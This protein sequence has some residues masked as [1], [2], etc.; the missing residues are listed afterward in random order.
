M[1]TKKSRA[2]IGGRRP[3]VAVAAA[4]ALAIVGASFGAAAANAVTPPTSATP[5]LSKVSS[6]TQVP[7]YDF[8]ST[9]LPGTKTKALRI[10]NSVANTASDYQMISQLESPQIAAAG[11]R[12]TSDASYDTFTANFT[13]SAKDY[14]TQPDLAVEVSVNS[15]YNRAGGD[16]LLREEAGQKLTLTNFS[17]KP[18]SDADEGEWNYSTQSIDFTKPVAFKIVSHFEA[19]DSEDTFK[20]YINGATT[21]ILTGSTFETYADAV[22]T[23]AETANELL[24]RAV[25]RQVDPDGAEAGYP[26]TSVTPSDDELAALNGNGF[27]FSGLNYAVSNTDT[28]S[29]LNFATSIGSGA[30]AVGAPLTAT[31]TTSAKNVNFAYQWLRN[32]VA[33]SHA[34]AA[35]YTP[36]SS[37]FAKKLSVK[38]VGSKPGYVTTTHQSSQTS[39]VA[40]GAFTSDDGATISG[41]AAVGSKL[42]AHITTVPTGTHAFQ[43]YA[44]DVAIKNAT[45]SNYTIP[46]SEI[47]A[48]IKVAIKVQSTDVTT[49]KVESAETDA[50][51]AGTLTFTN[52][53]ISGTAAVG[54]TLT[55]KS[56]VTSGALVRYAFFADDTLVQLSTSSSLALTWDLAGKHIT[57]QV[58]AVKAGYTSAT[59]AVSSAT[60]AVK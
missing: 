17:A 25:D 8:Q 18:D 52:P 54:K 28:A 41:T 55:A 40:I 45:A 14:A 44:N 22:G 56:T 29:P 49:L 34:T 26:W 48:T 39:A 51:V 24:F 10:S 3:V 30:A 32:G 37:D 42:T 47:G 43:W 9:T 38:V 58:S 15:G 46:A 59:S 13:L 60:A 50:V 57:V 31:I 53:T 20:V 35:S 23:P 4:T 33:I 1:S 27:Y 21:P 16:L 7:G 2:G 11:P 6:W 12:G 5:D 36:T 19:D